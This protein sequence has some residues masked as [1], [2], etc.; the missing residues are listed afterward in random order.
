MKPAIDSMLLIDG[1]CGFCLRAALWARRWIRPSAPLVPWQSVD[2]AAIG[3]T[4]EQCSH[5][6]QWVDEGR[7]AAQGAAAIACLLLT[8]PPPWPA[9]AWAMQRPL[10]RQL[11]ERC[12]RL[13]AENR[14]LLPGASTA[15]ELPA[16]V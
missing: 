10:T 6:V 9:C 13:V 4:P 8:A 7:V 15:C 3:V 14:H 11:A 1:D 2:I 5:A 12:Y 16:G